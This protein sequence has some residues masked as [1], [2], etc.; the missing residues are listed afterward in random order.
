MPLC[1]GSANYRVSSES[2]GI[3]A[4]ELLLAALGIWKTRKRGARRIR[5]A[6]L[7]MLRTTLPRIT[8][9]TPF[10]PVSSRGV[11]SCREPVSLP[12]STTEGTHET[13]CRVE[14]LTS[15]S[16]HIK[17]TCSIYRDAIALRAIFGICPHN[18]SL[19]FLNTPPWS[20]SL[21]TQA[22]SSRYISHCSSRITRTDEVGVLSFSILHHNLYIVVQS[23]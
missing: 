14:P 7:K 23:K 16:S 10:P 5:C 18:S 15:F 3:S 13:Q 11:R 20:L 4:A 17:G 1:M 12:R 2:Q 21:I 6:L 19:E 8:R 9:S 22:Y